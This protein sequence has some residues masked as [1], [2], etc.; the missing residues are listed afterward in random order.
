LSINVVVF[1][2]IDAKNLGTGAFR[3]VNVVDLFV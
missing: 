3:M 2:D 1:F